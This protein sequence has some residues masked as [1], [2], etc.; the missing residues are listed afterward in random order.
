MKKKTE[1][2]IETGSSSIKE[3]QRKRR[4][5]LQVRGPATKLT[6][7]ADDPEKRNLF[8]NLIQA[9][10]TVIDFEDA[11][12]LQMQD[13]QRMR[14]ITA[15]SKRLRGTSWEPDTVFKKVLSGSPVASRDINLVNEWANQSAEVRGD[16]ASALHV[17]LHGGRL[18]ILVLTHPR[19]GYFGPDHIRQLTPFAPLASQALLS[20]DLQRAV[21]QRDRFFQLSMD[22]MG[23]VDYSGNFKQLNNSWSVLLGHRVE[24][25]YR[26]SLFGFVHCDDA[27]MFVDA[28]KHLKKTGKQCLVEG[29]FRRWDGLYCWLSCSLAAY[30]DEKLC[31]IV[32]RDVSDRVLIE[33]Q[34][35]YDARHDPLTGLYNRVEFMERLDI[36][37]ARSVR[38]PR[39]AFVLF[40]MDLNGFK[41]V[42]DSL[43]H[44]VG[45]AL[46]KEVSRCLLEVVREVDTVARFGG[47]EFTI[48]LDAITSREQMVTV[49]ERIHEKLLFPFVLQGHMVKTSVSIGVA[50]SSAVYADA[51]HMLRDADTAMYKAKTID[52]PY[53]LIERGSAIRRPKRQRKT[54]P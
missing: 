40:Y 21:I 49:I 39:Y 28:I 15:T 13:D 7:I 1:H 4:S 46:L 36:A 47:D 6:S 51:E 12:I 42:N 19:P 29:R 5:P 44:A 54:L 41:A 43:G 35:A 26:N 2:V 23:I 33:R 31:Y 22:L 20:L 45:D 30:H 37:F 11:F 53:V 9:L 16:I 34:L 8:F 50:L 3:R 10:H 38:E 32:A 27:R 18:S 17:S 14:V 48:L 52:V 25:F 24:D